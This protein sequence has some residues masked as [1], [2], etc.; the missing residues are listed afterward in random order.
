MRRNF[1]KTFGV[2]SSVLCLLCL[3]TAFKCNSQKAADQ[4]TAQAKLAVAKSDHPP[5]P[6]PSLSLVTLKRDFGASLPI[7]AG[8]KH[9]YEIRIS[10][11]PIYAT[12]GTITFEYLGATTDDQIKANL[13]DLNVEF[14][15]AASERLLHFRAKAIS[16]GML[17]S[18][19]GYNVSRRYETL[20]DEQDFSARL[21][22]RETTEGKKHQVQ[23]A[24]FDRDR[25]SIHFK[26]NDLATPQSPSREKTFERKD[27]SVD[28]LTS[29][30][31]VRLQK[32]K[33]GQLLRFPV[34]DDDQNYEF[35][36]VVGK[37]EKLST[38]C[39]KVKTIRLEPKLFGPGKFFSRPGE[40]TMW[41]TDDNKHVPLRVI[42][43]TPRGT[44]SAKLLNFKKNCKIIE[45]DPEVSDPGPTTP[46]T[47][48]VKPPTNN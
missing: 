6:T 1:E 34:S 16:K 10:R 35:E 38:D 33:E 5:T 37:R 39:G 46:G 26:F 17:V 40:M 4:P 15:A 29:F 12:V 45:P 32:L 3:I 18:F 48:E 42:V 11:F 9:E 19:I 43:K 44:L 25:K 8:E 47:Q 13:G 28:V 31:L 14:K 27:G 30:Y 23:T 24:L 21:S 2:V 7:P 20:I 22:F 41:V 36:I